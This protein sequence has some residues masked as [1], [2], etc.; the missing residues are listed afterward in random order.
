VGIELLTER[1][2]D[3][4]AGVLSCW[5]RV[6]IFGTLPGICYAE[7]MTRHLY[8]KQIRIF[9]YPKFA[10]P[11]RDRLR[12]NAERLAAAAGI[13]IEF[14]RKRNVRNHGTTRPR[15]RRSCGRTMASACTITCQAG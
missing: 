15:A 9:D 2:K 12:E 13:E 14:I 1:L 3:Q 8:G 4:I 7:G 11:F 5:D 10:E 6:L